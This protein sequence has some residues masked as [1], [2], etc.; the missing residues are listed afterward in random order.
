M[1]VDRTVGL[2][3]IGNSTFSLCL[4]SAL[5][6]APAKQLLSFL[7]LN[8]TSSNWRF[9]PAIP[10]LTGARVAYDGAAAAAVTIPNSTLYLGIDVSWQWVNVDPLGGIHLA[11]ARSNGLQ[12]HIGSKRTSIQSPPEVPRQHTTDQ[13]TVMMS[14][15]VSNPIGATTADDEPGRDTFTKRQ[16]S[17]TTKRN[18]PSALDRAISSGYALARE[19]ERP[20]PA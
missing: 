1:S 16:S 9:I 15:R 17:R 13:R 11:I 14:G 6:L 8:L 10:R 19:S 4:T 2:P 12:I 7:P 18:E 20:T 3:Q 5:S